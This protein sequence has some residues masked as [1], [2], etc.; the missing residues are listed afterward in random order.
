MK[1]KDFQ[2]VKENKRKNLE[3][4]NNKKTKQKKET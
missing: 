2:N 4:N 1:N 3:V